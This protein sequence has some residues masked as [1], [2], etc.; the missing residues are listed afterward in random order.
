MKTSIKTILTLLV[1]A[2][3]ITNCKDDEDGKTTPAATVNFQ[4]EI[5]L[6]DGGSTKYHIGDTLRMSTGYDFN[7]KKFKLYLSHITLVSASSETEMEDILLA[8]VGNSNTGA[9]S[10][11]VKPGT[12]TSLRLGFGLDPEQNDKDPESFPQDH[13][14]SS[15]NQMYWTMLKY[16]F[17]ILEGRSDYTGQ[18]NGDTSDV[19]NAYH[20]G[21]DSLYKVVT[22]PINLVLKD[23]NV[24]AINLQ[25]V[26]DELFSAGEGIDLRNEPQTHS[27]MGSATVPGDFHI[28]KKFMDNLAETARI[29]IP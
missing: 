5:V 12:Y 7:L 17:A 11:R 28:A 10:A 22:Y 24:Q 9:F 21:L 27:E 13:P 14:L 2:F 8:D 29:E 16:R 25:V 20:P 26:F 19:L 4:T 1:L 3:I 18:L 15:Y 23:G 6:S